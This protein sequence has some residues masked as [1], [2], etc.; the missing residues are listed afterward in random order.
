[1]LDFLD[2]TIGSRIDKKDVGFVSIFSITG[3]S[4]SS[5]APRGKISEIASK[6]TTKLT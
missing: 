6:Y 4:F 5:H 3:L 2:D 1:M